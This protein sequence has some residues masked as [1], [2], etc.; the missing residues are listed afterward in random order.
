MTIA[1]REQF[2]QNLTESGIATSELITLWI[3]GVP[4]EADSIQ[5]AKAL[6]DKEHLTEWQAK[7]LLSGQKKLKFGNYILLERIDRNDIGDTFVALQSKLDRMVKILFLNKTLSAQLNEQKDLLRM[8]AMTAESDDPCLEHV[9]VIDQAAGR[10]MVVTDYTDAPSLNEPTVLAKLDSYD[11]PCILAQVFES[12]GLLHTLGI[13]H[14]A[15][16]EIDFAF[17]SKRK[18]TLQNLARSFLIHN[19]ASDIPDVVSLAEQDRM[20]VFKIAGR[21]LK[22]YRDPENPKQEELIKIVKRM[23]AGKLTLQEAADQIKQ[24]EPDWNRPRFRKYSS[25][26]SSFELAEQE[27]INA[28][29]PPPVPE[30]EM[31]DYPEDQYEV[32]RRNVWTWRVLQG[33]AVLL[34]LGGVVYLANS[35]WFGDQQDDRNRQIAAGS[36]DGDELPSLQQV[37]GTSESSSSDLENETAWHENKI[38]ASQVEGTTLMTSENSATNAPRLTNSAEVDSILGALDSLNAGESDEEAVNSIAGIETSET[39]DSDPRS[40][41]PIASNIADL[42]TS[43]SLPPISDTSDSTLIK[44]R[45]EN[46]DLELISDAAT[47][48]SKTVFDLKGNQVFGWSVDLIRSN[49]D[50]LEI[51]SMSLEGEDFQFAWNRNAAAEKVAGAQLANCLLKV[52]DG[53]TSKVLS[54]RKPLIIEGF[55]LDREQPKVRIELDELVNLPTNTKIELHELDEKTFGSVYLGERE[56]QTFT[57]KDPLLIHFSELPEYQLMFLQL[58]A[59]LK[60]RTRLD[61]S[62]QLQL[63]PGS[64]SKLATEKTVEAAKQYLEN[65]LADIQLNHDYLKKVK[66]DDH[67]ERYNLTK[68]QYPNNQ[69]LDDVKQLKEQL[70]LSE[71]RFEKFREIQTQLESF[72]SQPIPVTIFF[73]VQGQKVI[74][75]TSVEE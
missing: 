32:E 67:R 36:D 6:V 4:K 73:E 75:A 66:I 68:D 69:R 50:P 29:V 72:Y 37:T 53:L 57:R 59:D 45:G 2:L 14:G 55:Q 21:L 1:T 61:A 54:L 8:V 20:A 10:Y 62:L 24:L 31:E 17:D 60:N 46:F 63:D 18:I 71:T 5:L 26:E 56:D 52:S 13:S 23:G 41:E 11:L 39:G 74:L 64:R 47:S 35:G 34:L 40:T 49:K 43:V 12:T 51:A 27:P 48:K 15:L 42:P 44:L 7:F 9:H 25:N 65:Y 33:A 16:T 38:A 19:A 30:P 58:E 28:P 3:A 70:D 22:R